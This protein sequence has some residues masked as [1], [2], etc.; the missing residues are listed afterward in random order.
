[1]AEDGFGRGRVVFYAAVCQEDAAHLQKMVCMFKEENLNWKAIC[2][3][4]IDKDFTEWSVLEAEF[5]NAVILFCQW[6]VIKALFKKICDL[7]ISKDKREPLRKLLCELTYS[8]DDAK[9]TAIKQRVFDASNKDSQAFISSTNS[10]RNSLPK[11]KV[12]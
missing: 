5:P 4:V 3:V 8:A 6:H 1:M 7:D 9:Y 12:Y 2:V 10:K 11:S